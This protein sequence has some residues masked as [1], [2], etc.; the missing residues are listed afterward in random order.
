MEHVHT[1]MQTE[2]PRKLF[3]KYLIPSLFGMM[4]MAINILVDGLFVSHGVGD[5]GLA[6]VN[7]AVPIYSVILAFS[8]ELQE[9]QVVIEKDGETFII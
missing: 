2:Q 5:N 4:L 9:N 3:L 7:I 8:E 1:T 6:G